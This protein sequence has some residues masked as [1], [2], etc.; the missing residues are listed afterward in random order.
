LYDQQLWT[1]YLTGKHLLK[2][3]PETRGE[4]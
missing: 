3:N 4:H 2:V 1:H